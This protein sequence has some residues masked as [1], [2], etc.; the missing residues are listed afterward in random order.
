MGNDFGIGIGLEACTASRK[1]VTQ[2]MKI[3]DDAVMNHGDP[4]GHM[5]MRIDLV[6]STVGGPAG[7]AD[8]GL[9]EQRILHQPRFQ[10]AEFALGA[11]PGQTPVLKRG[12]SRRIIATVFQAFESPEKLFCDR[13]FTQ[14]SNN[15]AHQTGCPLKV[16]QLEICVDATRP[17]GK[18]KTVSIC[19]TRY[20]PLGCLAE[21]LEASRRVQLG[22]ITCSPLPSAS[23]LAGTSRVITDPDPI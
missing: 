16:L 8:A 5:R 6:R 23:A 20:G 10:V 2:L 9:A 19:V 13:L 15:T 21:S 12:D 7:V 17:N 22:L 1:F 4:S 18:S 14:D 3:F 11:T